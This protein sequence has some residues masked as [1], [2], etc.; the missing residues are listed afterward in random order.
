MCIAY[1]Q[2]PTGSC[3]VLCQCR[4]LRPLCTTDTS[5]S[6]RSH[7][8]TP[9]STPDSIREMTVGRNHSTGRSPL[10][11]ARC[12]S[13]L[14]TNGSADR[15]LRSATSPDDFLLAGIT[16]SKAEFAGENKYAIDEYDWRLRLVV[17]R[18]IPQQIRSK[19][20]AIFGDSS[21]T[22]PILRHNH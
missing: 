3:G 21:R 18:L 11:A 22:A 4:E 12:G 5:A 15:I 9:C 17:W 16:R 6:L 20:L 7:K 13:V 10:G 14:L 1:H 19:L 2:R 8:H